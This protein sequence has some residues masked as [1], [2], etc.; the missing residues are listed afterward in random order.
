VLGYDTDTMT[1]IPLTFAATLSVY[2]EG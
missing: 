2:F 1:Q